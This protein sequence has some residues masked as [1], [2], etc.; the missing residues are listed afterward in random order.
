MI[1]VVLV[2][3]GFRISGPR[4]AGRV[5]YV[6]EA[7]APLDAQAALVGGAVPAFDVLDVVVLYVERQ[8][9]AH[10]AVRADGIDL[11]VR[12]HQPDV[13]GRASGR[14]LGQAC[15]HSPQATQVLSPIRSPMSNT[16]SEVPAALCVTDN[17]VHLFFPAGAHATGCTGCRHPG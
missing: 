4:Q 5:V 10:A 8:Q 17:V 9:A 7:V 6:I 16:I 14:R 3:P 12:F 2:V 1:S 11:P 15:T 13:P